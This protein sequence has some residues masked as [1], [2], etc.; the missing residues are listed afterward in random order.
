MRTIRI[1]GILA[2]FSFQLGTFSSQNSITLCVYVYIY[3]HTLKWYNM[4][5]F[6]VMP[7]LSATFSK[8]YYKTFIN[9]GKKLNTNSGMHYNNVN[10]G[11]ICL[12]VL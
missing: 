4:V 9:G 11:E 7:F 12:I 6:V 8:L 2:L 1:F 3:T 10:L 5:V